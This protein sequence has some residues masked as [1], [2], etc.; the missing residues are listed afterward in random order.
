[1]R[2]KYTYQSEE[3]RLKMKERFNKFNKGKH[4]SKE[5]KLNLSIKMTEFWKT[6]PELVR[7]R[8]RK[9]ILTIKLLGYVG[10]KH[11]EETKRKIGMANSIA[12]KGHNHSEETKRKMSETHKKA[13]VNGRMPWDKGK[14]FTKMKQMWQNIEWREKT[15]KKMFISMQRKPN[16]KEQLLNNIIQENFPNMFKFVGD[17]QVIIGGFNPDFIHCNGQKFIIEMNGDYWHTLPKAIEKDK[18][19]LDAYYSYG[20]K[21]LTIWEHELK[22]RELVIEKINGFIPTI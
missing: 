4:L 22:N 7:E 15:L 14:Q 19:K 3:T 21:T 1:M 18:R 2:K 10:Y 8:I 11:S 17:G 12:N 6:H 16:K 20:Y 5:A 9:R 13:F